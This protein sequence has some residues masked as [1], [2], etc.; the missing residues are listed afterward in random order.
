MKEIRNCKVIPDDHVTAQHRLLAIAVKRREK[1]KVKMEK[2]IKWLKLKNQ[3]HGQA[4]K[5]IVL[6]YMDMEMEGVNG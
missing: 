3:D 4:I 2:R 6:R 1:R 5:E